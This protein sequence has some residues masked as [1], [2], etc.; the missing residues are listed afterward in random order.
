MYSGLRLAY[1]YLHYF[2]TASSGRG[3][4]IHSPFIFD[5]IRKVM[6]DKTVYPE[7]EKAEAW[8][9]K[10][11]GD[12]AILTV[13]DFGAGS[14]VS[15]TTDR[16]IASIAKYS[17]KPKKYGQLLFRMVK[18]YQPKTILELGTS[19]GITAAYLS[20]AN[21][22]AKLVTIEGSKAIA[23]VARQ[24]FYQLDVKNAVLIEGNFDDKLTAAVSQL[25]DV[26]FAFIDGN[27]RREPTERYFHQLL[28][29]AGND[30]I[31]I[32]DDIHWSGEMEAAWQTITRHPSVRCSIDLF[33][34]GI[35]FFR[36]GFREKQHFTIRF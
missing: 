22:C 8:R 25:S 9:K 29:A 12:K 7:Y 5:F 13:E 36:T 30:S 17:A 20:L 31:L 1:R 4:G 23:D 24:T 14:I 16:S 21:P 3:H 33:F 32:F 26:D 28:L 34:L 11:L 27:H 35:V 10:L 19:L 15:K 2:I 6:N 18:Y